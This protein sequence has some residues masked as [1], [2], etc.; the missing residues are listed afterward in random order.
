MLHYLDGVLVSSFLFLIPS[1]PAAARIF[2]I[3]DVQ[4]PKI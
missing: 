1:Q 2:G 4:Y 3:E